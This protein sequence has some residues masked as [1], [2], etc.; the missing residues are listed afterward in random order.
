MFKPGDKVRRKK[1]YADASW[2]DFCRRY[3]ECNPRQVFTVSKESGDALYFKDFRIGFFK[4]RFE[5]VKPKKYL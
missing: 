2:M 4:Y 5:L 3:V 1:E